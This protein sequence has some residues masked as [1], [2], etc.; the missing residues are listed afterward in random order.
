LCERFAS[1][2]PSDRV[3]SSRL[4]P[5]GN[6]RPA[7]RLIAFRSGARR[8]S[9]MF[10]GAI[11]GFPL[12]LRVPHSLWLRIGPPGIASQM[13]SEMRRQMI[14]PSP[15][16]CI[17]GR[18]FIGF[19]WSGPMEQKRFRGSGRRCGPDFRSTAPYN[20][21]VINPEVTRG[22]RGNPFSRAGRAVATAADPCQRSHRIDRA[23]CRDQPARIS[24]SL[25]TAFS[26][27]AV[28]R[29]QMGEV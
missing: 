1:D 7:R 29:V 18:L 26:R 19:R 16:G 8:K 21:R 5:W 14:T 9:L 13:S 2:R 27:P 12:E 11:G 23:A 15:S 20:L 28:G 24:Q 22:S 4:S 3:P 6:A 25:A 10:P 17:K